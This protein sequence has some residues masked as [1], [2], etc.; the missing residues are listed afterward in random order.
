MKN[1]VGYKTYTM[2]QINCYSENNEKNNICEFQITGEG[3]ETEMIRLR[4]ALLENSFHI[5]REESSKRTI[6]I[7]E[8]E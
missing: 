7:V 2:F 1:I 5:S 6:P 3:D 4:N 8:Q